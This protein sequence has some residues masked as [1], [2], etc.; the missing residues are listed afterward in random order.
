MQTTY[1]L[2]VKLIHVPLENNVWCY[3]LYLLY[4]I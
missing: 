1:E 4:N 3:A 2:M